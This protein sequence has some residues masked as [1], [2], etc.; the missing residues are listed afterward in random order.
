M[1]QQC[2]LD[3]VS[4]HGHVCVNDDVSCRIGP[5]LRTRIYQC[6]SSALHE[7]P[8]RTS[9]THAQAERFPIAFPSLF[10]ERQDVADLMDS[11]SSNALPSSKLNSPDTICVCCAYAY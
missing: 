5:I 3:K 11:H 10:V 9:G 7:E 1:R 8:T 4:M 2:R 6:M